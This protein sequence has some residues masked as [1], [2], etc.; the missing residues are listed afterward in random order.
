VVIGPV[1]AEQARSALSVLASGGSSSLRRAADQPGTTVIVDCGR[2]DPDS[3]ALPIIRGADAMLLLARPH[4]DELAHAALKLNEAQRWSRRPCFVLVGD[5]YSTRE[6]SQ[7][8]GIPVMGR[9][10]RDDKG[11]AMLCGHS[12]SRHSPAKSRLGREAARLATLALA[13]WHTSQSNGT[14]PEMAQRR[15][16]VPA[17]PASGAA[18]QPLGP[19][20]RNSAGT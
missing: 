8:L 19:Q 10:P 7:A 17:T 15:M 11:A 12:T 6:V 18:L 3:P 20:T 2:A 5:G 1:G 9:V 14:R 16:T 13:H 4:D